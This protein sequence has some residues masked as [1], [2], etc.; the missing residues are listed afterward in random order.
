MKLPEEIKEAEYNE[1]IRFLEI[2]DAN[3]WSNP[4][5]PSSSSCQGDFF[6]ITYCEFMEDKN[7]EEVYRL[8]DAADCLGI[9]P[10]SQF[11]S[12]IIDSY[13]MNRSTDKPRIRIL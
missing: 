9:E 4:E 5:Y 6:D 12:S 3:P 8:K 10:L 7:L 2:Y 11:C 1:L 13:T